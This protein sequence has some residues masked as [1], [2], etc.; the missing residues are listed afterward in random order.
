MVKV[1]WPTSE[2]LPLS[3]TL[4]PLTRFFLS[5]VDAGIKMRPN[6]TEL[7]AMSPEFDER[8]NSYF[9]NTPDKPVVN[10]QPIASCVNFIVLLH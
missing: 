1:L 3:S 8:W 7:A 4:F 9:A 10:Y 2:L 5:S 6:A